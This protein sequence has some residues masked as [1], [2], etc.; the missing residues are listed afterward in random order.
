MRNWAQNKHFTVEFYLK[1]GLF[2]WMQFNNSM[3][4]FTLGLNILFALT[5]CVY[6]YQ[7]VL[8]MVSDIL[9]CIFGLIFI[10]LMRK[11]V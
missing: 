2:T 11:S 9:G 8:Y 6:N 1:K 4:K 5:T 10:I 7:E 3:M